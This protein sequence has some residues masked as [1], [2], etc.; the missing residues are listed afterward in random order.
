MHGKRAMRGWRVAA[1]AAAASLLLSGCG[2]GYLLQAARGQVQ[3]LSQ[4]EP[5]SKLIDS[6]RTGE[7]LRRQLA[8]AQ[9]AREFAS[10]Q[11]GLP[12]NRSYRSFADIGR[13]FVVWSVVATPEF[14][15]QPKEW[16][17]PVVGCVAY[18]GYFSEKSARA[19]A[20]TLAAQGYDVTVGGVPAYSTLGRFSDPL[21]SSMLRYGD[22]ETAATL[23]HELAHQVIYV[24]DDTAF[25]EAFA[26]AVENAGLESWLALRGR[27]AD[28]LARQRRQTR[29]QDIV[30]RL[31]TARA[32]LGAIYRRRQP[33]ESLADATVRELKQQRLARLTADLRQIERDMGGR[34]GFSPWLESGLN[35]AHLASVATYWDC[36]PGFE[37]LLADAGG[38]LTA[39]YSSVR[40]EAE[41][42]AAERRA[43]L[44]GA[45][46]RGPSTAAEPSAPPP[47]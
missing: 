45:A 5:I 11:L 32:D 7:A 19:F 14:A 33:P 47:T 34:A 27:P 3:L 44:C 15:T 40:A 43:R 12:D 25:N 20:A 39:F 38:S 42:P 2:S 9:A 10:A 16:C 46:P 26:T 24:K 18:R 29:Q 36:V 21:L 31:A 23:F 22:T 35:N 17:F 13:P 28:L 6:P 41:R 8:E 30:Q 1:V 4:R 37:R